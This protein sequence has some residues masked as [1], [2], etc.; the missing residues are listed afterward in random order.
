MSAYTYTVEYRE[1]LDRHE[2]TKHDA[3]MH[4]V[5]FGAAVHRVVQHDSCQMRTRTI[6]PT[7]GAWYHVSPGRR[8]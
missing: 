1:E 5:L 8:A 2:T 3:M 4:V 7:V 6:W